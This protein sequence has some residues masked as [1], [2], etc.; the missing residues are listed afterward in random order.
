MTHCDQC[1]EA[2]VQDTD[3][4]WGHEVSPPGFD[5]ASCVLGTT[6]GVPYGDACAFAEPCTDPDCHADPLPPWWTEFVRPEE[7]P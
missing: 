1:G 5:P 2:I 3:G 7:T 6:A 4:T